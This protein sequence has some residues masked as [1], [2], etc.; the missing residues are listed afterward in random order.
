MIDSNIYI[1][2]KKKF[3][4]LYWLIIFFLVGLEFKLRRDKDVI[5][6]P[7]PYYHPS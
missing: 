6:R 5:P 4:I 1:F 7:N 2:L 3:E